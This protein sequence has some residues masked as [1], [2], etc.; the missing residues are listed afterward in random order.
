MTRI[1]KYSGG[2][3]LHSEHHQDMVGIVTGW[4]GQ[5]SPPTAESY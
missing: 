5:F 1:K 2:L 3:E 4:L